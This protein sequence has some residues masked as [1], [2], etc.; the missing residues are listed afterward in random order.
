[1]MLIKAMKVFTPWL[2]CKEDREAVHVPHLTVHP[3][4]TDT[5]IH[6]H[7]HTHSYTVLHTKQTLFLRFLNK[8]AP[9]FTARRSTEKSYATYEQNA[10][11]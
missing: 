3:T 1:M 2:P 7:T 6:T 10:R 9:Q 4:T 11:Q 5:Y 8:A